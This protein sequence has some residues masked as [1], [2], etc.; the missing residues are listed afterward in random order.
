MNGFEQEKMDH[1]LKKFHLE[2]LKPPAEALGLRWTSRTIL[3]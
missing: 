1:Y 3:N 2:K